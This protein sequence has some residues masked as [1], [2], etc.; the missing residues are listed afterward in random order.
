MYSERG[1]WSMGVYLESRFSAQG[2]LLPG[3]AG[4]TLSIPSA[5]DGSFHGL[6]DHLHLPQCNPY[7]Y[8]LYNSQICEEE[9]SVSGFG[10]CSRDV[11]GTL[12]LLDPQSGIPNLSPQSPNLPPESP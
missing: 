12:R 8:A 2:F 10:L 1:T 9:G 3:R 5:L 11:F 6:F 7:I 4:I